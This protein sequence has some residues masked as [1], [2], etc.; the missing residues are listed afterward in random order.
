M[1]SDQD[2][3]RSRR[4]NP[5]TPAIEIGPNSVLTDDEDEDEDEDDDESDGE[6]LSDSEEDEW[7][8]VGADSDVSSD[9]GRST[10]GRGV[11][12]LFQVDRALMECSS[13]YMFEAIKASM[14]RRPTFRS[15]VLPN[16]SALITTVY[17][18]TRTRAF[19]GRDSPS[20]SEVLTRQMAF[21]QTALT[22]MA[23]PNVKTAV[24]TDEL[25]QL[26]LDGQDEH[27]DFTL[28]LLPSA[29]KITTL[30]LLQL[31]PDQ[32]AAALAWFPNV[33]TL[34][35]YLANFSSPSPSLQPL[36]DILS[37]RPLL[38][39]LSIYPL[40]LPEPTRTRDGPHLESLPSLRRLH[41]GG[42]F[43]GKDLSIFAL[44]LSSTETLEILSIGGG[45]DRSPTGGDDGRGRFRRSFTEPT[46]PTLHQIATNTH[47]PP[48][49]RPKRP[50]FSHFPTTP[51]VRL[52]QLDVVAANVEHLDQLLSLPCL[53]TS[54]LSTLTLWISTI[55][56]PSSPPPS[57]TE[58]PPQTSSDPF[59]SVLVDFI[60]RHSATLKLITITS[61]DRQSYL[62]ASFSSA[63][64]LSASHG[65]H[66]RLSGRRLKFDPTRPPLPT[67]AEQIHEVIRETREFRLR[68]GE[69][70]NVADQ[71]EEMLRA[72]W[73]MREGGTVTARAGDAADQVE[74]ILGAAKALA[75][76]FR[77]AGDEWSRMVGLVALVLLLSLLVAGKPQYGNPAS[78]SSTT[79]AV[80]GS[81]TRAAAA[82][83]S[84]HVI[85][86]AATGLTFTP[87]SITANV[88]DTLLFEFPNAGHSVTQS[89]FSAPCSYSATGLD[90]G[91]TTAA[92]LSW[93]VTVETSDALWFSCRQTGHCEAGMV[94][95]VNA[96]TTGNTFE[97]FQANARSAAPGTFTPTATAVLSGS[98]VV[99]EIPLSRVQL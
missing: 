16:R 41:F 91:I 84:I 96:P 97:A 34:H 5:P 32:A 83:S 22:L 66:F 75:A 86:V 55:V 85:I 93:N 23:L 18:S 39:S 13:A 67:T 63:R 69:E 73:L 78:T 7:E 77:V 74:E 51:F 42:T 43:Y 2:R 50:I 46:P 99:G 25:A 29:H 57:S 56:E 87:N 95:A 17:F 1:V 82:S 6:D 68:E 60:T 31:S 45:D 79:S 30:S 47:L 28:A 3:A 9:G 70:G 4:I 76:Q 88:G 27:A 80:A 44:L 19:Y 49:P 14:V 92:G 10:L 64:A 71:V 8:E 65:I 94:F 81:P 72:A 15:L 33:T 48:T 61:L 20:R 37:S 21:T 90:S 53:A 59:S 40:R 12:A 62:E 52:R 54:P 98:G 36:V 35:L 11:P 26:Y 24:I 58:S 89:S 38:T